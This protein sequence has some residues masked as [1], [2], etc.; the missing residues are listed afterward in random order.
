MCLCFSVLLAPA[1]SST[2][3]WAPVV[4]VCAAAPLVHAKRIAVQWQHKKK[5]KGLGIGDQSNFEIEQNL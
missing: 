5:E 3:V 4:F 1:L 2:Q